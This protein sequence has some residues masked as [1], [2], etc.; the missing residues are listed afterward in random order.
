[1]IEQVKLQQALHKFDAQFDNAARGKWVTQ[2]RTAITDA[3]N[4]FNKLDA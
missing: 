3:A 2:A 1:M 4:K